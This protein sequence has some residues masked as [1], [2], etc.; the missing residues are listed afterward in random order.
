MDSSRKQTFINK[1]ALKQKIKEQ[2]AATFNNISAK[3][4]MQQR[5]GRGQ[6]VNSAQVNQLP[7]VSPQLKI[8]NN[9]QI[10]IKPL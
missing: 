6:M 9:E 4:V 10:N 7:S 2:D 5:A 3:K 1:V 8:T